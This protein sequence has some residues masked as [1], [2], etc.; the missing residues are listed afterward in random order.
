MAYYLNREKNKYL[1]PLLIFSL[2]YLVTSENGS[3]ENELKSDF[4]NHPSLHISIPVIEEKIWKAIQSY[5]EK[6]KKL[7]TVRNTGYSKNNK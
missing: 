2:M 5:D 1:V 3:I 7:K 6:L 4:T